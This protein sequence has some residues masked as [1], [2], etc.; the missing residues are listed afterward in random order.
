MIE[1]YRLI[2][3]KF[4]NMYVI[5]KE[6]GLNC[7][8]IF[9]MSKLTLYFNNILKYLMYFNSISL[10]YAFLFSYSIKTLI[11]LKQQFH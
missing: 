10:I 4:R 8:Q 3:T 11:C 5:I 1:Y 6:I 7:F 9:I 2:K